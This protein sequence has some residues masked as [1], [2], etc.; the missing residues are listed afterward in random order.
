[1]VKMVSL[2]PRPN[3]RP[4]PEEEKSN[5]I[6]IG[7]RAVLNLNMMTHILFAFYL[8]SLPTYLLEKISTLVHSFSLE[9]NT[10]LKEVSVGLPLLSTTIL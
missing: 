3:R 6:T 1:M 8:T 4:T 2:Y 7:L 5:D 10:T 9:I